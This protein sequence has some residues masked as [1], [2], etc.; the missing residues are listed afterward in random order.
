[1]EKMRCL[2]RS[3]IDTNTISVNVFSF[4]TVKTPRVLAP[5]FREDTDNCTLLLATRITTLISYTIYL[6]SDLLLR[7]NK[8]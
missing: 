7:P 3:R 1:M 4:V 5:E 8:S 6:V 2:S